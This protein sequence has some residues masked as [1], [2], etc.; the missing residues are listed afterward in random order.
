MPVVQRNAFRLTDHWIRVHPEQ[1]IP[2][3][4]IHAA[5]HDDALRSQVLP[6][7]EFL[8]IIVLENHDKAATAQQRLAS[9]EAFAKVAHEMSTDPTASGGGYV[10]DTK[11]S[12]MDAKLAAAASRLQ[13]GEASGI[14]D[15]NGRSVIL[16]RMPR[17]FKWQAEQL[18]QQASALKSRGDLKGAVEKDQEALQVYPYSL[19]A[20]V[21]MGTSL[22]AA[23]NAPRAAEVLRFA[24]QTYPSDPSAQFDLAL[25]LGQQPAEQIQA[26]RRA[27]DLDPDMTAAYESL[28]A[29]LYSAGQADQAI[30]TFRK[31]LEVDP[32]SAILNY[33]LGLALTKKGD[34]AGGK[35]ALALAKAID[36]AINH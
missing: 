16:R 21:L 5:E 19:R 30:D 9:G 27:I 34:E 4:G 14:V 28:G 24:V 11:L 33:D 25:T 26:L 13:Y 23:G 22:G 8:R 12:E 18:F 20:L 31:G 15:L 2:E 17:D 32:L 35:Q 10:G 6:R 7:H 3:Q 36:P 1:D 29:A